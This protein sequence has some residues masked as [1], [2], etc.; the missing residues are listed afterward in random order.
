MRYYMSIFFLNALI[1]LRLVFESRRLVLDARVGRVGFLFFTGRTAYLIN[2]ASRSK[3][4][5]R[6]FAALL[7]AMAL[8]TIIPCRVIR[9]SFRD[10]SFALISSERSEA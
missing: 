6:F 9:L 10:N 5:S 2:S 7:K 8:I 4:S 3:P 1:L